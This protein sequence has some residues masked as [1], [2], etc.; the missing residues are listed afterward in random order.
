MGSAAPTL[1][2]I[3]ALG[4]L[5]GMAPAAGAHGGE[6]LGGDVAEDNDGRELVGRGRFTTTRRHYRLHVRVCL[7]RWLRTRSWDPVGCER[8]VARRASNKTIAVE[9]RCRRDGIYRVKVWGRTKSRGG[10]SGHRVY[11]RS[12]GYGID[13]RSG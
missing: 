2:C 10:R 13:C 3:V 8:G 12:Q 4:G 9:V 6:E 7:Q 1:A 5:A 11:G